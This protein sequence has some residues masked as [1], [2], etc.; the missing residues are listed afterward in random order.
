MLRAKKGFCM[1]LTKYDYLQILMNVLF[2]AGAVLDLLF[3][4]GVL[5]QWA[6]FVGLV[7]A[8]AACI[9]VNVA[10]SKKKNRM[11][12]EVT[13]LPFLAGLTYI[14]GALWLLSYGAAIFFPLGF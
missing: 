2:V 13:G 11:R 14:T 5:P 8:L 9:T 1:K 4:T 6:T 10:T 12:R 7:L 3:L